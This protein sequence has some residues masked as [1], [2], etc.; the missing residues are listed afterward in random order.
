MSDL[1]R[2]ILQEIER[3]RL[4]PRPYAYFLARRS[5]FWTL[6]GV[7]IL[8]GGVSV[9]LAIFAMTDFAETGGRNFDDMPFDDIA[10]GLPAVWLA[11]FLA[12][13]VSAF[14]G[15]SNTKRGY[16]YRP[17]RVIA[18]AA[19]AS[20]GLGL[21]LHGLDAGRLAHRFLAERLPAYREFTYVPYAEWSRPDQGFLGGEVLSVEDALSLRLKDF[22]GREWDVDISSATVAFG[23]SLMEEGDIA[24]RGQRTG[25][26]SFKAKSI[27]AF[28]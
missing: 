21:V 16:R 23:G 8:L 15:L 27:D 6:A 19:L 10:E 7:S 18:L 25:P 2:K 28:D 26:S 3:R 22:G 13:I 14:L 11:C 9:A 12:F 1:S 17:S 24:V 20:I 4:T 5:V